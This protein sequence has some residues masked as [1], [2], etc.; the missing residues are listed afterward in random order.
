MTSLSY[1]L[2]YPYFTYDNI[3]WAST[4][5]RHLECLVRIQKRIVRI[6]TNSYP[7][8]IHRHFSKT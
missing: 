8:P 7:R 6:I 1:S 2:V 4:Y 3:V 5:P